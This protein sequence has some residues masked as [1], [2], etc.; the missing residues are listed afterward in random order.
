MLHGVPCLGEVAAVPLS[1]IAFTVF[2]LGTG[3]VSDAM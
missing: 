2:C 1:Q 3:V